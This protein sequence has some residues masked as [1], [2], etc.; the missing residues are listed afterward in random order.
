MAAAGEFPEVVM[1]G[2]GGGFVE[3]VALKEFLGFGVAALGVEGEGGGEVG[4]RGGGGGGR[5]GEG[6]G[7]GERQHQ[8]ELEARNDE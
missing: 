6:Y 5:G 8:R 7:R 3:G 4:A 2:G 1:G